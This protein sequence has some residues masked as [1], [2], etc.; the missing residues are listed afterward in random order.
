MAQKTARTDFTRKIRSERER[1][2]SDTIVCGVALLVTYI[3]LED[4]NKLANSTNS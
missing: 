1:H 4:L 3:A 2:K